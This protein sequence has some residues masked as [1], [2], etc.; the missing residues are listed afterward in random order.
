[1][2]F[3][4]IIKRKIKAFWHV[5]FSDFGKGKC[6]WK[7]IYFCF[8][9]LPF[10]EAVHLPVLLSRGVEI[11]AC[12]RG[13]FE[14]VDGVRYGLVEIGYVD[15]STNHDRRS[16]LNIQGLIRINGLGFHLFGAGL[17][18]YVTKGGVFDVGNDFG[19][20]VAAKI[21]VV[22]EVCVGDDNM[23]SYGNSI[24]DTDSHSIY[25]EGGNLINPNRKVKIGNHV[26]MGCHC[27]I[28]KGSTIPDGSI[29]AA[30]SVISKTITEENCIISE[31]GI[32]KRNVTW[33]RRNVIE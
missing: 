29:V 23:W 16:S 2:Y 11:H 14:F 3:Y 8:R 33:D 24:M 31:K 30:G 26:W 1:M 21:K 10:H 6:L 5:V 15:N 9:F 28:L 7:S 32:I 27:I 22:K 19:V 18:L 12:N 25:D 20:S 13:C 4:R 17:D